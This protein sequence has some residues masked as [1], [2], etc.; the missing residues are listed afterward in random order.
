MEFDPLATVL[1]VTH[2]AVATCSCPALSLSLSLSGSADVFAPRLPRF[3][4]YIKKPFG[5]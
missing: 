2:S 5:L 4:Q 3:Q 1:L